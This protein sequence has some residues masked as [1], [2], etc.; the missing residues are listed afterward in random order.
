MP[1]AALALSLLTTPLPEPAS[2][3]VAW[4]AS[5]VAAGVFGRG[6][7]PQMVGLTDLGGPLQQQ[8]WDQAQRMSD[9]FGDTLALEQLDRQLGRR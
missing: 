5:D 1:T 7:T 3:P 6:L 8:R 2:C 9:R 4:V